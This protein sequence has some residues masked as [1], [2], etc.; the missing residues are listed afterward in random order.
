MQFNKGTTDRA[1]EDIKKALQVGP[2]KVSD[3]KNQT[4]ICGMISG[5]E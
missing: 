2:C 5:P 1:K 3:V 4:L